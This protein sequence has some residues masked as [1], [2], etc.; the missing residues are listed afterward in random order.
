MGGFQDHVLPYSF[1][2]LEHLLSCFKELT[3]MSTSSAKRRFEIH[4][5][6]SSPSLMSKALFFQ[7]SMSFSIADWRNELEK[8]LIKGSP[9]FVP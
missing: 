1:D 6:L 7:V 9:C 5:L 2:V 8:R 3:I 4:S